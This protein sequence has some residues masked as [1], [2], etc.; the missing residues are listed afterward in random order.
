MISII[1]DA[2]D[3]TRDGHSSDVVI[4]SPDLNRLFIESCRRRGLDHPTVEINLALLNARKASGLR[5][6]SR[7]KRITVKNQD[8]Y[9]FASE[10]A[11]RFIERRDQVSLDQVLCDPDLAS[12]F[13]GIAARISPG[14][15]SFEYRWAALYLRKT[16]NLKPEIGARLIKPEQCCTQKAVEVK[17]AEIPDR[18]GV[19]FFYN[20]ASTLYVG[21]ADNLYK[22]LKKHLDHS[23]NKGFAHWL[24]EHGAWDRSPKWSQF[25]ST[26]RQRAW[27]LDRAWRNRRILRR[28]SARCEKRGVKSNQGFGVAKL[29]TDG[30]A[31]RSRLLS[32][33]W[34]T[35]PPPIPRRGPPRATN[36]MTRP[37]RRSPPQGAA[38][39]F[40]IRA[41]G[42][43]EPALQGTGRSNDPSRWLGF[44]EGGLDDPLRSRQS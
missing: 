38:R 37:P 14:Y 24:W 6:L 17:T 25:R 22:R 11:I 41:W 19:Y 18:A 15:S 3:E 12:E 44:F 39:G 16:R 33:A 31:R 30:P 40:W 5:G 35:G 2:Y 32:S 8:N 21:E 42:Q 1:R 20:Q 13:D 28:R 36:R 4:A 26:G 43:R 23:D 9:R 34:W 27:W 7:S 10:I 29:G